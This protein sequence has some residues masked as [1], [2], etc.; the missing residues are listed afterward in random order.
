M[1]QLQVTKPSSATHATYGFA[2]FDE[3]DA[4]S[5]EAL[6]KNGARP[7]NNVFYIPPETDDRGLPRRPG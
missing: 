6:P 7:V 3:E 2:M 1:T 4:A 5:Y